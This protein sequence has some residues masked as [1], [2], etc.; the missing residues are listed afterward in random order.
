VDGR[1]SSIEPA[2]VSLVR[3]SEPIDTVERTGF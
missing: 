3:F 2:D 1:M